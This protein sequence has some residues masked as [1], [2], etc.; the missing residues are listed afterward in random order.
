MTSC[1]YLLSSV[2]VVSLEKSNKLALIV[3]CCRLNLNPKLTLLI[4]NFIMKKK[5]FTLVELSI[6]LVIIGLLIGGILVGQSLIESAKINMQVKQISQF[7]IAVT[8]FITKYNSMPGD[9]PYFSCS[10]SATA[11]WYCNNDW[12]L[13]EGAGS[14]CCGSGYSLNF[15]GQMTDFWIHLGQSGFMQNEANF[16]GVI[17]AGGFNITSPTKNAPKA[18]L[19]GS[20]G[21]IGVSTQLTNVYGVSNFWTVCCAN[22]FVLADFSALTSADPSFSNTKPGLTNNQ[23]LAID[24]KLD[25]SLPHSGFIEVLGTGA[26]D[27]RIINASLPDCAS[28]VGGGGGSEA[29]S[30]ISGSG[31]NCAILV[32]M[33]Y[34]RSIQIKPHWRN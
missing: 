5:G 14:G 26:A 28:G 1:P 23:A 11:P 22:V 8:N 18:A 27:S 33:E 19:G 25:D 16:T 13:N 9:S 21:V 6:V 31:N 4:Y 20:T 2:P 15:D 32:Q 10:Y 7:D 12:V 30:Y 34:Q 3:S 17:P 24:T 29:G